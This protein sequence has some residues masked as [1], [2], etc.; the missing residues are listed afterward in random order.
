MNSVLTLKIIFLFWV[1]FKIVWSKGWESFLYTWVC[2]WFLENSILS[3]VDCLGV[4][5][6]NQMTTFVW[7]SFWI[8]HYKVCRFPALCQ[9]QALLVMLLSRGSYLW[10]QIPSSHPYGPTLNQRFEG[11]SLQILSL[12]LILSLSGSYTNLSQFLLPQTLISA[13]RGDYW[14]STA[15]S[16][17]PCPA[18]SSLETSWCRGQS[19]LILFFSQNE[20]PYVA[21]CPVS[22]NHPFMCNFPLYC[23]GPVCSPFFHQGQEEAVSDFCPI[24]FPSILS[25]CSCYLLTLNDAIQESGVSFVSSLWLWLSYS[26]SIVAK[27]FILEMQLLG[28]NVF[29]MGALYLFLL[30]ILGLSFQYLIWFIADT[31]LWVFFFVSYFCIHWNLPWGTPVTHALGYLDLHIHHLS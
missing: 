9:L 31:V 26:H 17:T 10:L 11:C 7:V 13:P 28:L 23:R 25:Y 12:F 14:F 15:C 18:G 27:V 8:L 4:L 2:N 1:F 16:P 24:V 20:S 22:R 21:R 6:R 30:L 19:H 29:C 3:L 5:I